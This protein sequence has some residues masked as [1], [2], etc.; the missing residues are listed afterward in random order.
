MQLKL[1]S[2]YDELVLATMVAVLIRVP[3]VK[4]C[5]HSAN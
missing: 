3:H 1:I 4:S 5:F 2:S